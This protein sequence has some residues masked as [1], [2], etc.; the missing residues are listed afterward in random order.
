MISQALFADSASL[1]AKDSSN[2]AG[3]DY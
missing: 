3:M 1:R 2:V